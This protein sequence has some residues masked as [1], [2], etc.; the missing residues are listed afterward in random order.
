M[1]LKKKKGTCGKILNTAND[2]KSKTFFSNVGLVELKKARQSLAM[3]VKGE[4]WVLHI[5]LRDVNSQM[6]FGRQSGNT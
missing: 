4:K 2:E 6:C 1:T 5:L 3:A